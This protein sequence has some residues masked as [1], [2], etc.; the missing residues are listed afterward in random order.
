[1]RILAVADAEDGLLLARLFGGRAWRF[2]LVV[3]C[4]DLGPSYLDCVATLANAPLL[5]VRGNHDV[6]YEDSLVMGG[7]NLHGHVHLAYGMIAR[8]RTHPS[9]TKLVNTCGWQVLE[10]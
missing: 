6:G 3:S 5:Y 1:M 2:D 8:E 10:L 7:T 9:G 4:G